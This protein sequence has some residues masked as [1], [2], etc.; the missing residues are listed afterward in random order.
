M[1]LGDLLVESKLTESD[2]QQKPKEVL[3]RYRDFADVFD[4]R[5]LPQTRELYQSYQ[6]IRNV[7]AAHALGMSFCVLLDARR[8][9]LMEEWHAVMRAVRPSDLRVRCKTLTWQELAVV[10]P[11]TLQ[12]FLREK[13]GIRTRD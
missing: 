11:W 5:A 13:Y 12:A 4:R 7:L 2:F 10:L 6:L 9:D 3:D 8:K 1:H